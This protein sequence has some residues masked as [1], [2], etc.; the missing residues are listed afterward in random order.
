MVG[1]LYKL[2]AGGDSCEDERC[3]ENLLC[4]GALWTFWN[5]SLASSADFPV[6]TF[7]RWI[8]RFRKKRYHRKNHFRGI[9]IIDT[10][11]SLNLRNLP[12][13]PRNL[14]LKSQ[15]HFKRSE[16]ASRS[17]KSLYLLSS[18]ASL[19]QAEVLRRLSWKLHFCV[20][21]G[22]PIW[23]IPRL[24]FRSLIHYPQITGFR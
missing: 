22:L 19:G 3:G 10:E 16:W 5:I 15:V 6:R 13:D 8:H 2:G 9:I 24:N 20:V 14:R 21:N 7:V 12:W 11:K 17:T 4:G 18:W 23:Q 1:S